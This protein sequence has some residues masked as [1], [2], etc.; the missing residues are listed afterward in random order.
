MHACRGV[1]VIVQ[2]PE[3]EFTHNARARALS[4]SLS[5]TGVLGGRTNAQVVGA[6]QF[7]FPR[8]IPANT[9]V[10]HDRLIPPMLEGP[11]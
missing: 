6:S 9:R 4:L 1:R 8:N 2:V 3:P 5:L 10:P 7:V 11:H